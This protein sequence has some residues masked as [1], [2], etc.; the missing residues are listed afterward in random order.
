MQRVG[1]KRPLLLSAQD[2]PRPGAL[3][4][5]AGRRAWPLPSGSDP[6]EPIRARRLPSMP[7]GT[8]TMVEAS[9][10]PMVTGTRP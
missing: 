10:E 4:S 9:P 3:P 5:I 1:M 8:Q 2:Q 7:A 6:S